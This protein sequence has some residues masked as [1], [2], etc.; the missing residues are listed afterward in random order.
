MRSVHSGVELQVALVWDN[1]TLILPIIKRVLKQAL[2][3]FWYVTTFF[4]SV[5]TIILAFWWPNALILYWTAY[6]IKMCLHKRGFVCYMHVQGVNLSVSPKPVVTH[7]SWCLKTILHSKYI[8]ISSNRANFKIYS[9]LLCTHTSDLENSGKK[10]DYLRVFQFR[11]LF[12]FKNRNAT[13]RK[14]VTFFHT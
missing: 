3:H 5:Y 10:A 7:K 12:I 14:K 13:L 4:Y 1:N 8:I 9:S 6:V 11:H 2:E